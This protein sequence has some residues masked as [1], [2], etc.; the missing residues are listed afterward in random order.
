MTKPSRIMLPKRKKIQSHILC[1]K[2]G[3]FCARPSSIDAHSRRKHLHRLLRFYF[4]P[5][6][7]VW[8]ESNVMSPL[9]S[10]RHCELGPDKKTGA[11][12]NI[13]PIKYSLKNREIGFFFSSAIVVV[14][15]LHATKLVTGMRRTRQNEARI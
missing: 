13:F 14:F 6:T 1:N 9:A 11:K 12:L 4:A 8:H 3:Q 7:N 2:N 15:V 5:T 10:T